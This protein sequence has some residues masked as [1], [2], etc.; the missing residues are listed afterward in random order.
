M[1]LFA[2]ALALLYKR[3]A[4]KPFRASNLFRGSALL[5]KRFERKRLLQYRAS[6]YGRDYDD[7]ITFLVFCLVIVWRCRRK[8]LEAESEE[9]DSDEDSDWEDD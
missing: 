2:Y 4:R 8:Y 5:Y 1:I 3:F 7:N 9:S 6:D